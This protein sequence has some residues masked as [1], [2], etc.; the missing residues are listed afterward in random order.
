MPRRCPPTEVGSSCSPDSTA[1]RRRGV[2]PACRTLGEW[3]CQQRGHPTGSSWATL[4]QRA[5]RCPYWCFPQGGSWHWGATM[6]PTTRSSRSR[7]RTS[8]EYLTTTEKVPSA[9]TTMSW[10]WTFAPTAGLPHFP[11]VWRSIAHGVSSS[12]T[13]H[14]QHGTIARPPLEQTAPCCFS[15]AAP[16]TV[17]E[18]I[19]TTSGACPL[20]PPPTLSGHRSPPGPSEARIYEG[21]H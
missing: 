11:K 7:R 3:L 15:E 14:G 12:R 21:V 19:S 16:S 5:R 8:R 6:C 10:R 17:V 4:T 20:R 13:R 2:G 18:A 9:F 1:T